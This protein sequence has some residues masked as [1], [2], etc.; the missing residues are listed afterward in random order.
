M[1]SSSNLFPVSL[2]AAE[3]IGPFNEDVYELRPGQSA[4]P[5]VSLALTRITDPRVERR[6]PAVV[7]VHGEFGNRRVWL[8]SAGQG[9]AADLAEQGMDVWLAEMRGH[10]LS[11]RNRHWLD[12]CLSDY[13]NFDWPSVN[14]FV[15]EQSRQHP[16]WIAAGLGALGVAYGLVHHGGFQAQVSGACFINMPPASRWDKTWG[17][18]RSLLLRRKGSIDGL[19]RGLGPEE[20]PV[21]IF[22]ELRQWS[23]LTRKGKHPVF[24]SLRRIDIPTLVVNDSAVDPKGEKGRLILGLLG[25]RDRHFSQVPAQN[26]HRGKSAML[27]GGPAISPGAE[28][29]VL[30][31][32]EQRWGTRSD[33][34]SARVSA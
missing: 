9:L 21:R 29:A 19:Q 2:M 17:L 26:E 28:A 11:P 30:E 10:G 25:S 13:G 24:D 23:G 22:E 4:D 18:L 14:A 12:N 16:V 7:L 8:S 15:V 3:T 1:R 5:S 27:P 31:W 33:A 34:M 20:E 6:G 32:L